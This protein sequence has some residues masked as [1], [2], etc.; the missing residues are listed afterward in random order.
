MSTHSAQSDASTDSASITDAAQVGLDITGSMTLSCWIRPTTVG[1]FQIL[2][3]KVKTDVENQDWAYALQL[4]DQGEFFFTYS[5]TG[6]GLATFSAFS[7]GL[8]L[9]VD[10]WVWLGAVFRSGTPEVQFYK[11]GLPLGAAVSILGTGVVANTSRD[12]MLCNFEGG[13]AGFDGYLDQVRIFDDERT[14]AEMLTDFRTDVSAQTN[15][16]AGWALDNDFVDVSGNAN[17]LTNNSLTFVE[18]EIHGGT[19]NEQSD[20]P[21][22]GDG[23]GVFNYFEGY[24]LVNTEVSGGGGATLVYRM[25]GFDSTLTEVVFWGSDQVDTAGNDYAGPGPL[26]DIVVHNVIGS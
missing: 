2:M 13:S 19:G 25:R 5:T 14:D 16:Q 4:D 3:G 22:L 8:G 6:S 20:G 21:I 15:L 1:A 24:Q 17:T 26:V 10:Q 11:N 23:G 9:L 12:F 18:G 7:V